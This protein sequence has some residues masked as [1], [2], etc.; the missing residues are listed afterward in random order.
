[1]SRKK[2]LIKIIVVNLAA[3]ILLLLSCMYF[4]ALYAY[5]YDL[6]R[7]RPLFYADGSENLRHILRPNAVASS[8]G[9]EYKIN[10]LG[11]RDR[12]Y[13]VAKDESS[14]RIICVGDS[15][16]FGQAV[17]LD[18]VYAKV[19]ERSLRSKYSKNIEVI[20]AGVSGYNT[21][22]EHWFIKHKLLGL[23]PDLIIL[24]FLIS[25][26]PEDPSLPFNNKMNI[27]H[28]SQDQQS[29]LAYYIQRKSRRKELDKENYWATYK[30]KMWDPQGA[31][32]KRCLQALQDI[33]DLTAEH[34]IELLVL[35]IPEPLERPYDYLEH[36]SQLQAALAGLGIW[37][38]DVLPE[39][40]KRGF[41]YLPANREDRHPHPQVHR[42]YAQTALA[43]M[44]K[45]GL[46]LLK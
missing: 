21:Y 38:V 23:N 8:E 24:G 5:R 25:N 9:I 42:I 40:V 41:F 22:D 13:P 34:S 35:I 19:L 6:R 4:F 26:D 28:E 2:K 12:E 33:R 1:M 10:A 29:S 43:A 46:I 16:T 44:E 18:D 37:Y 36:H 27:Q 30:S 15:M 3:F 20:N 11:F 39:M 14:Y 31:Q 17:A 7:M 32:W 45:E